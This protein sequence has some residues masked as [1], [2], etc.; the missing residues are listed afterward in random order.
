MTDSPKMTTIAEGS[1]MSNHDPVPRLTKFASPQI[2]LLLVTVSV[3][4]SEMAAYFIVN[5]WHFP[6]GLEI[7][8]LDAI[9]TTV[10]AFLALYFLVLR[11]MQ[12]QARQLQDLEK[13]LHQ[14]DADYR[15]ILE[16]QTVLICWI[17]PQ[18]DISFMNNAITKYQSE[19]ST[20][21][22]GES[23]LTWFLPEDIPDVKM[24]LSRLTPDHPIE[25]GEYRQKTDSGDLRWFSWTIRA[26][27]NPAGVLIHYQAVGR[28]TT[29]YHH[30]L[31]AL[32]V[33]RD[34]LEQKILQRTLERKAAEEQMSQRKWELQ[35]LN[36]GGNSFSPTLELNS[37][38]AVWETLLVNELMVPSGQIY[39]YD[40]ESHRF[41][42]ELSWS[43][44]SRDDEEPKHGPL[45]ADRVF[46]EMKPFFTVSSQSESG[47]TLCIPLLSQG[48]V[49]GVID[50][51][52]QGSKIRKNDTLDFF[53]SLGYQI[54]AY[55]HMDRLF[56]AEKQSR[57]L[58]EVMRDASLALSQTLDL[59]TILQ[60]II[61]SVAR[62]VPEADRICIYT[63][64]ENQLQ[65]I[66]NGG[67]SPVDIPPLTELMDIL[68]FPV[69]WELVKNQSARLIE[70]TNNE[71]L[72]RS[73]FSWPTTR[74]WLGVPILLAG[75]IKG[76]CCLESDGTGCFSQHE[77]G[78]TQALL[79]EAAVAMQNAGLY[80][81]IRISHERLKALSRRVVE[82][83]EQ[84]RSYIARELHD[85]TSQALI[86]LTFALEII[87]RDA[88]SPQA[89]VEGV[90]ELDRIINDILDNLHH[91]AVDLRPTA[92]DH[93]GLIPAVRQYV[94]G[95]SEKR[96]IPIHLEIPI[97][98]HRL[99]VTIETGLYRIIQEALANVIH[100][101]KATQ[102]TVRIEVDEDR[103]RA[104]VSDD[105][106]GFNVEDALSSGRLGLFGMSE[107]VEMLGGSLSINSE[108]GYGTKIFMEIPYDNKIIDR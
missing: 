106:V 44:Y 58:A 57:Q 46:Q 71:S 9:V 83:Q 65:A 86:G 23:Y 28:D 79:A 24:R 2:L 61:A 22:L 97:Q 14:R 12:S 78:I 60:T 33:S 101:A 26:I 62:L 40:F 85:D 36:S 19:P 84:E 95:I 6:F 56:K 35:A 104:L 7:A 30:A 43:A 74:C 52:I 99:P 17:N 20:K 54:G 93:L 77:I 48:E 67:R 18:G 34:E 103:V 76:I 4:I 92:L 41:R 51:V 27:Y 105:G 3:L 96:A 49:Q 75:E 102:A 107:R 10:I 72:W 5:A 39:S 98:T 63:L 100:H 82:V 68:D 25:T 81:E 1:P 15:G 66:A 47:E 37:R 29:D 59:N 42:V 31:E 55:I 53:E 45:A 21:I 73:E 13:A 108:P 90:D 64:K 50:L 11:P 69:I 87:K 88:D 91:L 70:D 32:Q 89:V 16:D 80:K 8:L 38:F 94:H